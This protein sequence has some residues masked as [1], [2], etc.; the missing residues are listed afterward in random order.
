MSANKPTLAE[1]TAL[2]DE[3]DQLLETHQR[4]GALDPERNDA[5]QQRKAALL[6]RVAEHLAPR[7]RGRG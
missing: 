3:H 5:Y 6:G 1:L 7:D 4:D 2:L